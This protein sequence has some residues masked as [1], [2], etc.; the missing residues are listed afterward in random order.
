MS[1][2]ALCEIFYVS[3]EMSYT[4]NTGLYNIK[5]PKLLYFRKESEILH[6]PVRR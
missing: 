1:E 5:L 4:I 3:K 2:Y 6:F